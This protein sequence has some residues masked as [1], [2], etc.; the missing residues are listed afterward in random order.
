[1]LYNKI[2]VT[3]LYLGTRRVVVTQIRWRIPHKFPA[4]EPTQPADVAATI[5][6]C[7]GIDPHLLIRDRLDR[8]LSLCEGTP[9]QA[10]LQ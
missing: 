2:S 8:P 9:I 3:T 6:Q 7:L 5:Y 1:M 4:T 10:I